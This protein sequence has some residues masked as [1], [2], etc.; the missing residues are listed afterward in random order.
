M[1]SMSANIFYMQ[2]IPCGLY[3][4]HHQVF[5]CFKLKSTEGFCKLRNPIAN[6]QTEPFQKIF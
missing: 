4:D 6:E 1:L 2:D 3:F 5:L